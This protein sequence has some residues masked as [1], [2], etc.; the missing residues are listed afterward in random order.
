MNPRLPVLREKAA[1]LPLTP[2]VYLMKDRNG[3]I[4]YVGKSRKMRN[5]VSSY[6]LSDTTHSIKTRKMVSAVYDFSYILCDTEM[7]A[8]TL[9]NLLIK[10]HEP[11][12]NIKLKDAKSYPYIRISKEAYPRITVTRRRAPDGASYFGPYR[13][14][15]EAYSSTEAV[16][17][18]L[19]LP[20]C[21]RSF[22]RDI[23]KERPCLYRQM[24]RCVA[25]CTG[26]V[27]AEAYG[28]LIENARRIFLGDTAQTEKALTEQMQRAAEEEQYELAAGF[29]DKLE[30]LR[31]L[32]EKQ[33]VSG[34]ERANRDALAICEDGG[35]G[36]LAVLS[37]R[38]GKLLNKQE[39]TFSALE[40]TDE[41]SL[42]ALILQYYR[43]VASAPR[44]V[45]TDFSLAPGE[46]E[47]LSDCLSRLNGH[48]VTVRKPQRGELRRLCEMALTN[49]RQKAAQQRLQAEHE[50][51][52]LVR[53]ASLLGL[54]V[55]PDR[56]EAY[57]ISNLGDAHINASMVVFENHR[58]ARSEYRTFRIRETDGRDDYGAMRE[59][60][61]R[62]L[63]HIGDG[64]SSLGKMPDLILLDGGIGQVHAVREIL[65]EHLGHLPIFGMIKDEHH[66]TRAM[67]DGER[68]ISFATEPGVYAFVY[69]LQEEAHRVAVS[70]TMGEKRRTLRR[71]SLEDIPGIGPAKARLL[72][73]AFG[74]LRALGEAGHD[75]LRAVKGISERDAAAVETYFTEKRQSAVQRKG[76]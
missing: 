66:K 31:R 17:G 20:V 72:L 30:A 65:P 7:E 60:L 49:A 54:E 39:Y 40:M 75:A 68:E 28:A 67:T 61:R 70:H 57:D 59:A 34:D 69:R 5:R 9:E 4:I 42:S 38:N 47:L 26:E 2:G 41:E 25:P 56:V 8:L 11:R 76:T 37:I 12:Y 22:P 55:C 45:L 21:K 24:G 64:S 43:E 27:S 73:N 52:N 58:L 48:K 50:D 10:E 15:Q 18:I 46:Y 6:F 53:L 36:V 63:S 62:R 23:G 33:K 3:Q 32:S 74:S 44:E 14:A 71:S 51:R 1:T 13:S 19:G 29:R 35:T 16:C